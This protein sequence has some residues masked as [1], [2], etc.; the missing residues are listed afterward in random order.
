MTLDQ[1]LQIWNDC[2]GIVD[3][4]DEGCSKCPLYRQA[5]LEAYAGE[6]SACTLLCELTE[7]L[8]ND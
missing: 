7:R 6:I 5:P 2:E 3:Q 1:A 8:R 4:T